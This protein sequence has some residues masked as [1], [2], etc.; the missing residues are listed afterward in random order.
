MAERIHS[1]E[2]L[3]KSVRRYVRRETEK[4]AAALSSRWPVPDE[5]VHDAR[6]RMK[7]LRGAL[8][9]VRDALGAREFD[10][11]NGGLRDAARPLS[12]V[13]DAKV[14]VDTLDTVTEKLPRDDRHA[15]DSIRAR[16][17]RRHQSIRRR[18][19]RSRS[20][21]QPQLST[22]KDLAR[23]AERWTA[24]GDDL[25]TIRKGLLRLY[26]TGRAAAAA[27][28][29][30]PDDE[31]LHEWRKQAKYLWHALDIVRPLRPGPIG[32]MAELAEELSDRLGDDHDLAVLRTQLARTPARVRTQTVAAM[33]KWIDRRRREMQARATALG[34]RLYA[35]KPKR[36]EERL[37]RWWRAW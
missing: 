23:R 11:D 35:D 20:K 33:R 18:V 16:L 29:K 10:R 17:V 9:L 19:L 12:A 4:A 3:R 25:T 1:N 24:D 32:R 2:R 28:R 21:L 31:R 7:R 13:R 26:D 5:A 27:A 15:I 8:R 36:L 14:L 37:E 22:L 30:K 6:K 34:A